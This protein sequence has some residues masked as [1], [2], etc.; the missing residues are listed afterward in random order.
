MN[1]EIEHKAKVDSLNQY[2][3]E[4]KNNHALEVAFLKTTIHNLKRDQAQRNNDNRF[5]YERS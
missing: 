3:R 1:N 5:P 2:I 4:I